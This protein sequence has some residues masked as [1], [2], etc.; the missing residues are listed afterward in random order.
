[1]CFWRPVA[2]MRKVSVFIWLPRLA[3]FKCG[4]LKTHFIVVSENFQTATFWIRPLLKVRFWTKLSVRFWTNFGSKRTFK[5]LVFRSKI[6]TICSTLE[7]AR[8]E[9]WKKI[10]PEPNFQ[11]QNWSRTS[12]HS[13]ICIRQRVREVSTFTPDS[14]LVRCPRFFRLSSMLWSQNQS[15][16][17]V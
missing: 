12:F 3:L 13:Y 1:M 4:A 5:M 11:N 16:P 15:T 17:C 9:S 8:N 7:F 10:G 14:E 6:R 2:K